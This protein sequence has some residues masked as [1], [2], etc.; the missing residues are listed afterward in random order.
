MKGNDYNI[1]CLAK[2]V[3]GGR[4]W[5]DKKTRGRFVCHTLIIYIYLIK[6]P[7]AVKKISLFQFFYTLILIRQMFQKILLF[8]K[9]SC[10][11]QNI[12]KNGFM[13]KPSIEI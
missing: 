5:N 7:L 4:S 2:K 11:T 6:S 13:I 12:K 8:L 10:E 1:T 3:L 9:N